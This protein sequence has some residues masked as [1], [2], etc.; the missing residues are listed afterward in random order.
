[1]AP[2]AEP[3][4]DFPWWLVILAVT[5]LW[6]LYEIWSDEVY[7]AS[8]KALSKGLWVTLGVA[9]LSTALST[10]LLS[11]VPKRLS[12]TEASMNAVSCPSPNRGKAYSSEAVTIPDEVVI[13]LVVITELEAKRNHPELGWTARQALRSLESFRTAAGIPPYRR[14]R[15]STKAS[16]SRCRNGGSGST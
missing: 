7:K 10:S 3:E 9:G 16:S 12:C 2:N 4:K 6:L 11:A 13:P 15:A 1:M 5:G 14:S 8:L